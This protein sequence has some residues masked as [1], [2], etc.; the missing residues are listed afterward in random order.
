MLVYP[1]PEVGWNVPK[2]IVRRMRVSIGAR[3][4]VT[5]SY[6]VFRQRHSYTYAAFDRLAESPNLLRVRPEEIFCN[7][8]TLGRCVAELQGQPL[9]YDDSHL[10]E[11]AGAKLLVEQIIGAMTFRGWIE[12]APLS[13]PSWSE[14]AGSKEPPVER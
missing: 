4:T 3:D 2:E 10:N 14:R 8:V 9:Y 5:T 1:V 13:R 11:S 12:V 6:D 7:T